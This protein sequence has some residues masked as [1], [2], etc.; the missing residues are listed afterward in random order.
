MGSK[1]A[2]YT[3]EVLEYDARIEL[4]GIDGRSA[5]YTRMERVRFLKDTST[6]YDH[7]WGNG[8]AFAEHDVSHGKFTDKK[9]IG[10]RLRSAV[11]LPELQRKGDELAFTFERLLQNGF[12]APSEWWL[13]A[14][15]YHPTR[16]ITLT[17]LFPSSRP[18]RSARVVTLENPGGTVLRLGRTPDGRQSISYQ[19]ENPR[20]GQRFT[21]LWDW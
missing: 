1:G 18:V 7:G 11:R 6:V 19:E 12:E 17:V 15:L 13:E 14:E 8:I 20:V 16:H 3:Y 2:G 5:R 21:V 10:S 4:L 9:L